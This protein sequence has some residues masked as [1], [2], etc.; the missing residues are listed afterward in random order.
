M[1]LSLG[2]ENKDGFYGETSVAVAVKNYCTAGVSLCPSELEQGPAWLLS[3]HY[4]ILVK[5]AV[6]PIVCI[7]ERCRRD[8]LVST[9]VLNRLM[10]KAASKEWPGGAFGEEPVRGQDERVPASC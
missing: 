8:S 4:H 1:S 9:A 3:A 10:K 7:G 5:S 6:G 2:E